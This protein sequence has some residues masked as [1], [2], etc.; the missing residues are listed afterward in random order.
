[1]PKAVGIRASLEGALNRV[2]RVE[3]KSARIAYWILDKT[4]GAS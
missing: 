2:A 1:M 3:R 4:L